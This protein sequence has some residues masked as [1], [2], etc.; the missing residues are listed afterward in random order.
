MKV[1]DAAKGLELLTLKGHTNHVM[2]V[3]FSPDGKRLASACF[4][5]GTVKVW[6]TVKGRELIS[7]KERATHV[8]GVSFSPDGK[9]LA[10]VDADRT[11]R[12][13]LLLSRS[14]QRRQGV[15]ARRRTK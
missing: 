7:L 9:W 12:L 2:S 1:W 14:R 4:N 11:V 13:W 6:D 5:D 3:A 8:F 10:S 15:S